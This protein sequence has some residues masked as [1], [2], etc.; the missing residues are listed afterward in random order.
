[1][2][3][4]VLIKKIGYF[5]YTFLFLICPPVT[6]SSAGEHPDT[7]SL[8]SDISPFGLAAGQ[9][10]LLSLS[11]NVQ[12]LQHATAL[13]DRKLQAWLE[14]GLQGVEGRARDALREGAREVG[15]RLAALE[16]RRRPD[17]PRELAG[18]EWM[19][20]E[21]QQPP[22]P[23]EQAA[24]EARW[25]AREAALDARWSAMEAALEERRAAMEAAFEQRCRD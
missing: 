6:L 15:E 2:S 13:R 20:E 23:E 10:A 18:L 7:E 14:R 19:L 9:R 4:E 17:L 1:C 25:R 16:E 5:L 12:R 24:L 21:Q 11:Q 3:I 22:P 8:T